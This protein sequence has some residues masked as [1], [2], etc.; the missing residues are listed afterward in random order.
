MQRSLK[1][2]LPL[3][4]V[5][6]YNN[7]LAFYKHL[8]DCIYLLDLKEFP[9]NEYL[10]R[11]STIPQSEKLKPLYN[12]LCI[13]DQYFLEF[14]ETPNFLLIDRA[15]VAKKVIASCKK[16]K[17][18]I[19]SL[20][21]NLILAAAVK[22]IAEFMDSF[23]KSCHQKISESDNN[24][25]IDA[26]SNRLPTFSTIEIRKLFHSRICNAQ[27]QILQ[28]VMRKNPLLAQNT[29]VRVLTFGKFDLAE[30]LINKFSICLPHS[31]EMEDAANIIVSC[32]IEDLRCLSLTLPSDILLFEAASRNRPRLY[33]TLNS[34]KIK[35]CIEKGASID[36]FDFNSYRVFEYPDIV[37]PL[38]NKQDKYMGVNF[39]HFAVTKK[40]TPEIIN[41]LIARGFDVNHKDKLGQTPL[42]YAVKYIAYNNSICALLLAGAKVNA[43]NNL[44]ETPLHLAAAAGNRS[45]V[46]ILLS[47]GANSELNDKEGKIPLAC[48]NKN[49]P[50][51]CWPQVFATPSKVKVIIQNARVIAQLYRDKHKL[52]L[53][54]PQIIDPLIVS[55]AHTRDSDIINEQRALEIARQH[56]NKP[57]I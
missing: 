24:S 57:S 22:S 31:L 33:Q 49:I 8:Q 55:A 34:E 17:E 16:M 7:W 3:R 32:K 4:G 45:S 43:I 47:A 9:D 20:G 1:P 11:I 2:A 44:G 29:L 10:Y 56:F 42:H 6:S 35:F 27:P 30:I 13:I 25:L 28:E 53:F 37:I 52:G 41:A 39:L 54:T 5:N 38:I 21:L 48:I 40:A 18:L 19:E 36:K 51:L 15:D 50:I 12:D 23:L 26:I 14:F 46:E